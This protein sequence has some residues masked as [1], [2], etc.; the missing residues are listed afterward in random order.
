MKI[1]FVDTMKQDGKIGACFDRKY[2]SQLDREGHKVDVFSCISEK[3]EYISE[4]NYLYEMNNH[5]SLTNILSRLFRMTIV[6]Y[7]V[8]DFQ[9]RVGLLE[10]LVLRL[11]HPTCLIFVHKAH[12]EKKLFFS[13][14]RFVLKYI[15]HIIVPTRKLKKK[16]NK[17]HIRQ[18]TIVPKYKSFS[19]N[20]EKN[21]HL[22]GD[23]VLRQKQYLTYSFCQNSNFDAFVK[24]LRSYEKMLKTNRISNNIAFV[25]LLTK[26]TKEQELLLYTLALSQ[27]LLFIH[28]TSS[29]TERR[30]I[31]SKSLLFLSSEE[32]PFQEKEDAIG[33]GVPVLFIGEPFEHKTHTFTT[34][35]SYKNICEALSYIFNTSEKEIEKKIEKER[36]KIRAIFRFSNY[37]HKNTDAYQEC[38]ALKRAKKLSWSAVPIDHL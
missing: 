14:N 26:T 33:F 15:D 5:S 27:P 32:T 9:E 7:D 28:K 36:R 34:Q 30:G 16:L 38:L 25:V 31:I 35:A 1:L 11:F 21:I 17:E 8:V 22:F 13:L 12:L 24:M 20:P 37:V 29:Y 6:R 10:F 2:L 4:Y 3:D 19:K 23:S 18:C